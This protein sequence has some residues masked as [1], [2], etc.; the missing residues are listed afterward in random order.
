MTDGFLVIDVLERPVLHLVV[1][2]PTDGKHVVLMQRDLIERFLCVRSE[3]GARVRLP[4]LVHTPRING[5]HAAT[6]GGDI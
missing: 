3:R 6:V 1:V 4:D 5:E 2:L